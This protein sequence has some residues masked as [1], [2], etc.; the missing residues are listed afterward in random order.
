MLI[1]IS[2]LFIALG[3]SFPKALE[4]VKAEEITNSAG[5]VALPL[6]NNNNIIIIIFIFI[7]I[8][9]LSSYLR[10]LVY[11]NVVCHRHNMK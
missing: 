7:I 6:I 5:Y 2:I 9:L 3:T 11:C 4:I 8:G 10:V 1:I